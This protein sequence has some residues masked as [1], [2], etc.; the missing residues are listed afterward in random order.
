MFVSYL[1]FVLS[2][3]TPLLGG[4][5]EYISISINDIEVEELPIE[6]SSEKEEYTPTSFNEST[7]YPTPRNGLIER[8][9]RR[10]CPCKSILVS[11]LGN[12]QHFQPAVMGIYK[13]YQEF[14]GRPAYHGKNSQRLYFL[15]G[16]GWLLGPKIGGATG[17]LHN[18]DQGML[19]PYLITHVQWM[20][21]FNNLWNY[22]PT[23]VVRCA[24]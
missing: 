17:F 10:G 3:I 15:A 11:S 22:D 13:Y 16:S 21:V 20:Y 4:S 23:L 9:R 12:A 2:I 14:N 19:C 8:K 6:N 5:P 1:I 24:D 7:P 18:Q